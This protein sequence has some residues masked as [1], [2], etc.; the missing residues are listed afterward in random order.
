MSFQQPRQETS[1]K[2]SSGGLKSFL[3][4]MGCHIAHK[5]KVDLALLQLRYWLVYCLGSI[6]DAFGYD[7]A[8]HVAALN[9]VWSLTSLKFPSAPPFC[10]Q[11][12]TVVDGCKIYFFDHTWRLYFFDVRNFSHS[13]HLKDLAILLWRNLRC[14]CLR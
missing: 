2:F 14:L 9:Q 4:C 1:Y 10:G 7:V 11:F 13:E 3:A 5:R 8:A 6:Q 12:L